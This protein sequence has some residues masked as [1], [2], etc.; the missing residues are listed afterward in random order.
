MPA[1]IGLTNDER[2]ELRAVAEGH[3]RLRAESC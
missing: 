1:A 2:D 3:V